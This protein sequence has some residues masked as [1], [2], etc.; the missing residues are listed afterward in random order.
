MARKRRKKSEALPIADV[1]LSALG[2]SGM[3][4][5]A[6]RFR[7]TQ[8]YDETVGPIVAK[9]SCPLGFSRGVLMLKSQSTAW[10]NELTFL[11]TD[12]MARLNEALGS[13][14]IQDI[15]VVAGHRYP[16]PEPIEPADTPGQ[17]CEQ[18]DHPE[19][20]AQIEKTVSTIEDPEVR[21]SL[22]KVMMIAA[23]RKRFT[24]E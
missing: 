3:K 23:R 9:R 7:I 19:D 1:I 22:R 12:I 13:E 4:D 11:K 10:Q 2:Q 17:W 6:R 16:D 24:E 20:L 14:V 15:R 8:I 21:Q 18:D 5:Q